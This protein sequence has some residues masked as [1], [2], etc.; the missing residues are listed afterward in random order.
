MLSIFTPHIAEELYLM[1]GKNTSIYLENWPVANQNLLSNESA[2]VAIQI[3][4]KTRTIIELPINC[5][6]EEA[7]IKVK[8]IKTLDKYL[9]NVNIK[10]LVYIKNKIIN[11]VV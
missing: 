9:F 4:G 3:N 7:L 11:F 8:S 5:E 2:K 6:K 10:K 1:L